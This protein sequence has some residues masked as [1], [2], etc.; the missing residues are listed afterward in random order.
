VHGRK[1][2]LILLLRFKAIR[3]DNSLMYTDA[4]GTAYARASARSRAYVWDIIAG[5][6]NQL[7]S[8]SDHCCRRRQLHATAALLSEQLRVL[9]ER[10]PSSCR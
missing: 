10:I 9:T 5:A 6:L 7:L 1:K 3:S 4:H 8:C 2:N